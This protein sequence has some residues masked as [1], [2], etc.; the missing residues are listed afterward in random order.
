MLHA[1]VP[2]QF[3]DEAVMTAVYLINRLPTPLLHMRSPYHILFHKEP[4]YAFLRVFGCA[5]YPWLRPYAPTKLSPHSERCVFLGYSPNHVGYRCLNPLTGR[6]YVTRDVIFCEDVF[7][8]AG[9][10]RAAT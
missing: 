1:S 7:P 9:A 10:R 5:S 4:D 2:P 8:F 6:I 3:W